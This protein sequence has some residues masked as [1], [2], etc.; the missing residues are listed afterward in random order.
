M[1]DHNASKHAHQR[2]WMLA[3]VTRPPYKADV[4]WSADDTES[5]ARCK[6]RAPNTMKPRILQR[7]I[8]HTGY[9]TIER[10]RLRLADGAEAFREV[11]SHGNAAAVL[12]HDGE[13]R[14]GRAGSRGGGGTEYRYS[15]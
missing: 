11:E 4:G 3:A 2:N 1:A 15:D 7:E 13:R 12:P 8:T 5:S 14:C 9:L 6:C 10:L